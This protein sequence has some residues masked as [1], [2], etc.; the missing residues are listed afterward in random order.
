MERR[1]EVTCLCDKSIYQSPPI[2]ARVSALPIIHAMTHDAGISRSEI[3][4][5]ALP[6]LQ[7]FRGKIFVIK[8]GGSAME[9][10][11][12]VQ[13]TLRDVVFME[14]VGVKPVLVHGGGKAITTRMR[15]A[16]LKAQFVEGM[17][18][19]DAASLAIVEHTLDTV[20]N[21]MIVETIGRFGGKA[22]GI[23]GRSVIQAKKLAPQ[24]RSKREPLD[25]GLV[26]DVVG[27][28]LAPIRE[29]LA[30]DIV[31]V[32][33]PLG[34]DNEGTVLNVNADIAAGAIAAELGAYKLIYISDVRGIMRDPAQ[35]DS[36]IPSINSDLIAR[37]ISDEIIEG[38][39]IPKVESAAEALRE[40]VAKAH[41]IDGRVSHSLL[42]EFFTNLGIGT[43]IVP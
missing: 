26:G 30:R 14:A 23:S 18:V 43:E 10:E 6:F 3:L 21:P 38:G 35:E 7:E 41:L 24:S 13:R 11:H 17:R 8:Y 32:I 33:S 31:P 1:L 37:L 36:L 27:I 15:E 34:T 40:G 19:T 12:L 39:M 29:A 5:E 20:I 42:L 22:V 16:G 2:W 9:D 25:L 4:I 28:H